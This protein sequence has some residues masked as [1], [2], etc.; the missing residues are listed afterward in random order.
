MQKL[1]ED[2]RTLSSSS[3]KAAAETILHFQQRHRELRARLAAAEPSGAPA[4]TGGKP[5][6][7]TSVLG[8]PRTLVK[9]CMTRFVLLHS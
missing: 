7:R 5:P 3:T 2:I 1:A 9:E 4:D 8:I 6:G